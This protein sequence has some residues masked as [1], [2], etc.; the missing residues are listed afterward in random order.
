MN[1]ATA[2]PMA[3]LTVFTAGLL[4]T[5]PV[6]ATEVVTYSYD[7]LARLTTTSTYDPAGNRST[8]SVTGSSNPGP[9]VIGVIVVSRGLC[10]DPTGAAVHDRLGGEKE[11]MEANQSAVV[12]AGTDN[13][14]RSTVR[15]LL[16]STAV[17]LLLQKPGAATAQDFSRIP[18][19]RSTGS[20]MRAEVPVVFAGPV[21][22]GHASAVP[23]VR[24]ND[25]RGDGIPIFRAVA[26]GADQHPSSP[27]G[28]PVATVRPIPVQHA[29]AA[30]QGN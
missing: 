5:T 17:S 16:Y 28:A 30:E 23:I 27:A 22:A 7:A 25:R 1:D 8:Y 14:I 2:E 21:G 11:A 19:K 6:S 26:D 24:S 15:F 18:V 29:E 3:G 9:P 20:P 13:I 4:C 12:N 10:P